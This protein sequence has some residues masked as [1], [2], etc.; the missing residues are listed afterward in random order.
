[1]TNRDSIDT[2]CELSALEAGRVIGGA[3]QPDFNAIRQQAQAYCPTTV[4]RYG[5]VD[6]SK[7]NRATAQQM[8]NACLAEMG[9][10]KAMFAR[11]PIQQGIDQ[12]FPPK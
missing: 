3:A 1:M 10:F 8:G 5:S 12:A 7:V 9:S 6:P 2:L 11:G 4:A